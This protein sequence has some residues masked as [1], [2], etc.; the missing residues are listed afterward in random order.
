MKMSVAGPVDD[1]SHTWHA[2]DNLSTWMRK[3]GIGDVVYAGSADNPSNGC[4][5]VVLGYF[6]KTNLRWWII[7]DEMPVST[8]SFCVS[9]GAHLLRS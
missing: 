1:H 5:S 8:P 9:T 7:A 3:D 2:Q 6:C 4:I